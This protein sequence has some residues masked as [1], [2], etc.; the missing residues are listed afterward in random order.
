MML[1]L[2]ELIGRSSC[3]M[4]SDAYVEEEQHSPTR[5]G[6]VCG[7]RGGRWTNHGDF[8]S[9]MTP[10]ATDD[11]VHWLADNCGSTFWWTT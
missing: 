9:E 1:L 2:Q 7:G 6:G 3:S 8:G 4:P 10:N 5:L 11:G